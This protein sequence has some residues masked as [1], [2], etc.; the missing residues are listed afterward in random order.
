[1][2]SENA[3]FPSIR[4]CEIPLPP[5]EPEPGPDEGLPRVLRQSAAARRHGKRALFLALLFLAL[6]GFELLLLSQLV[7]RRW[8]V[9]AAP[10][11]PFLLGGRP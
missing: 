3:E 10:P 5:E 11:G 6:C 2:N 9:Y 4:T 8:I 7:S 1:M